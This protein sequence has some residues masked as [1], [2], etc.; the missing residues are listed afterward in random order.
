MTI[1]SVL[2]PM[3]I[4]AAAPAADGGVSAPAP[5]QRVQVTARARIISAESVRSSSGLDGD[6]ETLPAAQPD[7]IVSKNADGGIVIEFM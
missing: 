5:A 1:A 6:G 7:R 3:L 4:M 2:A